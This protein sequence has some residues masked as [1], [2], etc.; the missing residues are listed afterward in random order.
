ML[1]VDHRPCSSFF[2]PSDFLP[3]SPIRNTQFAGDMLQAS[4]WK[5]LTFQPHIEL[6]VPPEATAD[7]Y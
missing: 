5:F 7:V 6:L 1:S 4:A 2:A 3:C